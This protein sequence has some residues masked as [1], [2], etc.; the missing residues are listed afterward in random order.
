M[1]HYKGGGV[2]PKFG[3]TRYSD[4]PN[5]H[6]VA[7]KAGQTIFWGEPVHGVDRPLH[8]YAVGP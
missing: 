2:G 7:L 4:L 3:L 1:S 6:P 5:M 8:Y